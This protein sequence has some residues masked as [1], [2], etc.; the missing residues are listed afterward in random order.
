MLHTFVARRPSG[1]AGL[2]P[3]SQ[4][5]APPVDWN[6]YDVP[7]MWDSLGC[8][9][10]EETWEQARVIARQAEA[11]N[12]QADELVRLRER[13]ADAWSGG[14]TPA[15]VAALGKIDW[16]IGALRADALAASTTA[17]GVDG[18]LDTMKSARRAMEP[19]AAQWLGITRTD[20]RGWRA[21][22]DALNN[23]AREIMS[24]ADAMIGDYRTNIVVPARTDAQVSTLPRI[25]DLTKR[26][27]S[28][29]KPPR[30]VNAKGPSPAD[31]VTPPSADN[32]PAGVETPEEVWPAPAGQPVPGLSAGT[33]SALPIFPGSPHAPGGGAFVMP[34]GSGSSGYV[35]SMPATPRT[36]GQGFAPSGGTP[37]GMMPMPMQMGGNTSNAGGNGLSRS[38]AATRWEVQKGGPALIEPGPGDAPPLPSIDPDPDEFREWFAGTAMPWRSDNGPGEQAPIVTIRRGT[39]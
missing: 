4:W 16:L 34:N 29:E 12:A 37:P 25:E 30:V 11:L 39:T 18:V 3:Q 6:D 32:P 19:I 14:Q 35:V 2:P 7:R 27:G 10:H 36:A 5:E 38:V 21:K 28:L 26:T 23:R 31:V 15:G 13:L 24:T 33:A 1:A 8:I 9:D 22:A 20:S 17:R